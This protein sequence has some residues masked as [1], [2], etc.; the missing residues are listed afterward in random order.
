MLVGHALFEW[1]KILTAMLAVER[2]FS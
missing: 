2:G 1:I